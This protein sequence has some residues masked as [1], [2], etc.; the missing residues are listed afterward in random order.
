MGLAEEDADLARELRS[1]GGAG[2]GEQPIH[3]AGQRGDPDFFE[4]IELE[5][6]DRQDEVA[7][8][9][10]V[11]GAVDRNTPVGAGQAQMIDMH[12][13]GSVAMGTG[14]ARRQVRPPSSR[15]KRASRTGIVSPR[16]LPA[17]PRPSFTSPLPSAAS[18]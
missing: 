13:P 15:S 1:R 14:R 10:A 12:R 2:Q 3:P 5:I 7:V 6:P 16:T 8:P 9:M 17:G 11:K 18:P 4:R